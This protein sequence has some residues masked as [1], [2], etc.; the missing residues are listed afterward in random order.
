MKIISLSVLLSFLSLSLSSLSLLILVSCLLSFLIQTDYVQL[1]RF[2]SG[3]CSNPRRKEPLPPVTVLGFPR[4]LSHWPGVG[5]TL[6]VVSH[7][8]QVGAVI[9]Q[10]GS[11]EPWLVAPPETRLRQ[12][13]S[14][15]E[16]A[17]V[18]VH[19]KCVLW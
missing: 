18:G 17:A 10:A 4:K 19:I 9:L 2:T 1:A 11:Q 8:I 3:Q 5:D 6:T 7:W 15:K 16:E 13:G 14:P 12:S